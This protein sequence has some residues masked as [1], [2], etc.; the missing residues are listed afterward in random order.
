LDKLARQLNGRLLVI[1][2]AYVDFA[3]SHA[4]PLLKRHPNV[5]VLRSFSKS[6]S[7]AGMRIGLCFAQRP[8][9]E[10]LLKVKDS[11]NVSR[12]ALSA[13]AA[14]LAD[15]GWMRR[16]VER[17]KAVRA[18]TEVKLRQM[19]FEVPPSQANFVLARLPGHD[20]DAIAAGLRRRGILVR[21]FPQSFFRDSLRISIGTATEMNALF[22]AL[23]PLIRHLTAA[24]GN[25]AITKRA[26]ASKAATKARHAT[27]PAPARA[28]GD[29]CRPVRNA[30]GPVEP[31][32]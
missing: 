5:I 24:R 8:L 17:I 19:G 30:N 1:D 29:T 3:R 9:I 21:H 2:E 25:G 15:I 32:F 14:A 18:S 4:L 31:S 11:Y 6:F 16:N 27:G 28:R 12:L 20:L 7:L 10:Q 23:E 22:K 13:G 26:R